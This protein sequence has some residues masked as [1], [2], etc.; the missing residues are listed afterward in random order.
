[1]WWPSWLVTRY[2]LV[3]VDELGIGSDA[4]VVGRLAHEGACES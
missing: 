3:C 2:V 1:M 4:N